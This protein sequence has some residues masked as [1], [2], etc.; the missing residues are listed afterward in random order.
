MVPLQGFAFEEQVAEDDE[1]GECDH[2][3]DDLKLHEREWTSI[4]FESD[5]VGR[6]LK[7]ILEQGDAPAEQDDSDEWEGFEP[8][9]LFHLEMTV[10]GKSHKQIGYDKKNDCDCDLHIS[11]AWVRS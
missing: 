1:Y 7:N 8:A 10:P 5:A 4:F 9:E 11:L 3:L 2:F 6:D